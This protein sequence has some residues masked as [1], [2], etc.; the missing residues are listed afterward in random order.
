MDKGENYWMDQ[1]V[2][3]Y[4]CR[5]LEEIELLQKQYGI[6]GLGHLFWRIVVYYDDGWSHTSDW[7]A[8]VIEARNLCLREAQIIR[9][10]MGKYCGYKGTDMIPLDYTSALPLRKREG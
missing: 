3:D 8:P 4:E 7:H 10:S 1:G 2:A 9:G 6:E 5:L